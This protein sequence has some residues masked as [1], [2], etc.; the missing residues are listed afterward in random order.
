[1]T[2]KGSP[3]ICVPFNKLPSEL[4]P[5]STPEKVE[6][7]KARIRKQILSKTNAEIVQEDMNRPQDQ[8]AM[9]LMRDLGSDL[10]INAFALNFRHSNGLL[11]DDVEEA[12][13][14]MQRVVEALSVDSPNDNPRHIPLYLTS[15]EFSEDLY[16]D[17]KRHYM[18]RLGLKQ[19]TQDL[20]V[21]RNVVMS[22]F[23][24]EN[25]FISHLA[26]VFRD[27]VLRETEVCPTL[28]TGLLTIRHAIRCT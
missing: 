9:K 11:N 23:P 17:C 14:L 1:L 20:M 4:A 26:G 22:P 13:Y 2:D 6:A 12:N 10:N 27:T 16:G 5:D 3:F 28:F 19:S 15:T 24:S 7:E 18:T 8:K 21:L 25:Q